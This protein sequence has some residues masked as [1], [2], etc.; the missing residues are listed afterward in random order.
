MAAAL[1]AAAAAL[2]S[3]A[4]DQGASIATDAPANA[5]GVQHRA[6]RKAP[7]PAQRGA[8]AA[9]AQVG[10]NSWWARE[11]AEDDGYV[12]PLPPAPSRRAA[13]TSASAKVD[14]GR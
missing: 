7:E 13:T 4:A 12:W 11:R 1:A 5:E 10:Q 3:R 2:G 14:G 8:V 9:P 6:E